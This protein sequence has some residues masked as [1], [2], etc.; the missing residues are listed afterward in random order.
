M[1]EVLKI[2]KQSIVGFMLLNQYF[3][4]NLNN[5]ILNEERFMLLNQYFWPNLNNEILN[6]ERF[7]KIG[8]FSFND[9]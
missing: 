9:S 4:P 3:W 6:E 8:T 7:L 5:E 1:D 2:G